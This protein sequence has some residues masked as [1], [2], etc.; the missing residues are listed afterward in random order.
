MRQEEA[1]RSPQQ[2][3]EFRR[4][5][6]AKSI[7]NMRAAS[8]LR[9][10]IEFAKIAARRVRWPALGA[11]VP[12]VFHGPID[13]LAHVLTVCERVQQNFAVSPPLPPRQV[14]SRTPPP[15]GTARDIATVKSRRQSATGFGLSDRAEDGELF[16]G[17]TVPSLPAGALDDSVAVLIASQHGRRLSAA[18]LV[19]MAPANRTLNSDW[20]TEDKAESL[21]R[22]ERFFSGRRALSA[23]RERV[24]AWSSPP[25]SETVSADRT[26]D[27]ATSSRRDSVTSSL[28]ARDVTLT[29][30]PQARTVTSTPTT[31]PQRRMRS[32]DSPLRSLLY[33]LEQH[34]VPRQAAPFSLPPIFMYVLRSRCRASAAAVGA[35]WLHAR[36][37]RGC[38]SYSRQQRSSLPACVCVCDCVCARVCAR[39]HGCLRNGLSAS[40]CARA[41]VVFISCCLC[42]T[43]YWTE[44][45]RAVSPGYRYSQPESLAYT[46]AIRR[47]QLASDLVATLARQASPKDTSGAMGIFDSIAYGSPAS[48]NGEPWPRPRRPP[49]PHAPPSL[50]RAVKSCS[51]VHLAGCIFDC[52][53]GHSQ[54]SSVE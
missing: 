29:S 3:R 50:A 13:S 20:A 42:V 46:Q 16:A 12:V 9:Q 44:Q 4:K 37:P 47:Q 45:L 5:E 2:W 23:P 19:D 48:K 30:K 36:E 27:S 8:P 31:S 49:L 21:L 38:R 51:R 1:R 6:V 15:S 33:D 22:D 34:Q 41:S 40:R 39:V 35:C 43:M 10:P 32:S 24:F 52:V 17:G 26:P 28:S 53:L 7:E 54:A 14:R 25:G 18:S 11:H